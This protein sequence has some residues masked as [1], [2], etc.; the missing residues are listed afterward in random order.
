MPS[1]RSGHFVQIFKPI[2]PRA[3]RMEKPSG[4]GHLHE[5]PHPNYARVEGRTTSRTV[6]EYPFYAPDG[7]FGMSRELS[8]KDAVRYA[9]AYRRAGFH[10]RVLFIG[11]NGLS[12]VIDEFLPR[13]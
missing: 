7:W 6:P 5:A 10:S 9:K 3:F 2:G 8:R 12:A 13:R 4:S 11:N 1:R